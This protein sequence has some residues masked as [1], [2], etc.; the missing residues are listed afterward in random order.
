MDYVVTPQPGQGSALTEGLETLIASQQTGQRKGDVLRIGKSC[1]EQF[2]SRTVFATCV[3]EQEEKRGR[4]T[5]T[6]RYY[7]VRTVESSDAHMRDCLSAKGDWVPNTDEQT[8]AAA[9]RQDR[10]KELRKIVKESE[11]ALAD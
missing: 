7:D 2:A 4:V 1:A 10:M 5:V 8:L 6:S 9:R 3:F 11:Q